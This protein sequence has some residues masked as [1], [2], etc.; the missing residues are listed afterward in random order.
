MG[1]FK[2]HTTKINI[3]KNKNQFVQA[4]KCCLT[5]GKFAL[6]LFIS[7]IFFN[8]CKQKENETTATNEDVTIAEE[9]IKNST[10]SIDNTTNTIIENSSEANVYLKIL[11]KNYTVTSKEFKIGELKFGQSQ[12][13]N[14][15]IHGL[16]TK[17]NITL[18]Q[19]YN[20]IGEAGSRLL[21]VIKVNCDFKDENCLDVSCLLDNYPKTLAPNQGSLEIGFLKNSLDGQ[22]KLM[23]DNENEIILESAEINNSKIVNFK[24]HYKLKF[25]KN[26]VNSNPEIITLE[27][28]CIYK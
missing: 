16:E 21:I 24:G 14:S 27:G 3:M 11:E 8:S 28:K 6:I 20:T 12:Q 2:D 13:Y 17:S 23:D 26:G 25:I 19:N 9:P 22:Y 18:E 7:I 1:K 10:K 5:N 15:T 4:M